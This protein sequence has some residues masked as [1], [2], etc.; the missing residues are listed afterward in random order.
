[1]F[2]YYKVACKKLRCSLYEK[3]ATKLLN[4]KLY[5]GWMFDADCINNLS[6]CLDR[7]VEWPPGDIEIDLSDD[8]YNVLKKLEV[9]DDNE[10][11]ELKTKNINKLRIYCE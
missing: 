2:N 9:L 5:S 4:L 8:L 3:A 1:M 10:I 6:D 11:S 7:I